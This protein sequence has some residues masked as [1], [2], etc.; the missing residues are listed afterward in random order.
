MKAAKQTELD[1]KKWLDSERAG[2][3]TCGSYEFCAK[4]DKSL[5]YPCASAYAASTEVAEVVKEAAAPAKAKRTC[6]RKTVNLETAVKVEAKKTCKTTTAKTTAKKAATT[7]TTAKK[8][9]T[10]A[11]K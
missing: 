7:K 5:E 9:T 11:S 10:K 8:A 3:D 6:T 2:I 1:V 4:C